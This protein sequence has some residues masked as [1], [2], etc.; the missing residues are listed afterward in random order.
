MNI[1]F[2]MNIYCDLAF[3]LFFFLLANWRICINCNFIFGISYMLALRVSYKLKF[4]IFHLL[5][6][7]A[8]SHCNEW[9]CKN[10]FNLLLLTPLT[11]CLSLPLSLSDWDVE[12]FLFIIIYGKSEKNYA[13]YRRKIKMVEKNTKAMYRKIKNLTA[14]IYLIQNSVI[15]IKKFNFFSY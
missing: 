3:L 13:N 1:L 15:L 6:S 4:V 10:S 7:Y 12:I 8:S 5:L 2:L 11:A 9:K 14:N